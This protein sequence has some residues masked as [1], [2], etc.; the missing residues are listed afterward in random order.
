MAATQ[1]LLASYGGFVGPFDSLS[2]G[3]F[4]AV[5]SR[6]LFSAFT[7]SPMRM[8][9]Q[10]GAT[11]A[12]IPFNGGFT[13]VD[14]TARAALLGSSDG[15]I[16]TAY[17]Q[18]GL[19]SRDFTQGTA[20]N[21]PPTKLSGTLITV[22]GKQAFV[23]VQGAT[24]VQLATPSVAHGIGTGDWMVSTILKRAAA[25]STA[26]PLWAIGSATLQLVGL[27]R[28]FPLLN[29]GVYIGG[30]SRQ[31]EPILTNGA[32]YVLTFTRE[33]GT[34]KCYLNG[35]VQTTTYS[36]STN[37]TSDH[38]V[39]LGEKTASPWAGTDSILEMVWSTSVANRAAII[40]NQRTY[41]GV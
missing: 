6:R 22:N 25:D 28:G 38:L 40:A 19:G 13:D 27:A 9:V 32:T 20:A 10:P 14:S 7:G 17:D 4:A 23:G 24:G 18:T 1:Q 31:F 12:I 34:V 29:A 15:C 33:S 16:V 41:A 21:Q 8:R 36:D 2:T 37:I 35:T 11:D 26:P 5:S 3:I 30:T 39:I